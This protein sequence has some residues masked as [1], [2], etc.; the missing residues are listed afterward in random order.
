M[1]KIIIT[2]EQLNKIVNNN[3]QLINIANKLV[4]ELNDLG[5]GSYVWHAATT[6]SVYIRFDDNRMGT[7]Q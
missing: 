2:E 5:I 7:E 3:N 6:G 1:A 4:S